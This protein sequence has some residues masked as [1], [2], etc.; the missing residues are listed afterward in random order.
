VKTDPD[1]LVQVTEIKYEIPEGYRIDFTG[2]TKREYFAAMAMQGMH[3]NPQ[4][5][6]TSIEPETVPVMAVKQ[7]DALIKELNRED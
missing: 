2:L 1:E 7:A 3:A 4:I 5:W 6:S